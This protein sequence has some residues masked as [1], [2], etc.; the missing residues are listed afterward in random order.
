[1]KILVAG[2]GNI[3]FGDDGF[4]PE[5]LRRLG[6]LPDGV[7]GVDFGI[8][9]VDLAYTMSEGWD[10]VIFVDATARGGAPGT[11]YVLEPRADEL[12]SAP[13]HGLL[14]GQA[15][16]LMKQLGGS[17]GRLRLVGCEPETVEPAMGLSQPVAAAVPPAVTLLHELIERE[18][19]H[20]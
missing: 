18:L 17:I 13:G 2:V 5:V 10:A 8:R 9:G 19:T 1:V 4:G 15:L 12:P 14:P 6:P 11:L 16:E 3:F 20:A 7:R